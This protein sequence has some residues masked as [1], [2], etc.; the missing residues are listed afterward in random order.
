MQFYR[1]KHIDG[2][3]GEVGVILG[4][5]FYWC[6]DRYEDD[7]GEDHFEVDGMS[8]C[9]GYLEADYIH[10]CVHEVSEVKATN[11]TSTQMACLIHAIAYCH[12]LE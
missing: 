8:Y 6:M 11:I 12:S 1:V 7:N 10:D 5:M 4:K 3:L 2:D 9:W